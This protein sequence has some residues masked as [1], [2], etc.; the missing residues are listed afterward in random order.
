[1][2]HRMAATG[3]QTKLVGRKVQAHHGA[4]SVGDRVEVLPG[5]AAEVQAQSVA[6]AQ[7]GVSGVTIGRR[8]VDVEEWLAAL[9]A[10]LAGLARSSAAARAALAALLD[11]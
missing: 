11:T 10:V 2:Q 6:P 7:E 4:T 1:M 5:A 9:A 8:T 3:G